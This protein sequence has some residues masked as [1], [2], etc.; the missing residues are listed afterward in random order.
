MRLPGDLAVDPDVAVDDLD[1]LPRQADDPL[2][3]RLVGLDRALEDR[4][5]PPPRGPEVEEELLDEQAVA[6]RLDAARRV[7]AV[8]AAVRANRAPREP[9][10]SSTPTANRCR[11]FGQSSSQ[12]NPRIVGAIDPVGTTYASA[13]K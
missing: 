5:L 6:A 9:P 1:R 4:H 10:A 8:L 12:W 11:Q 7:E 13:T 2:D 3:V